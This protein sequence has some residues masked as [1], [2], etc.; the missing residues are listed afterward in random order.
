MIGDYLPCSTVF[1][2]NLCAEY[3]DIA[4]KLRSGGVPLAVLCDCL[5]TLLDCKCC[6]WVVST[7]EVLLPFQIPIRKAS[8]TTKMESVL[9]QHS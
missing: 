8:R 4:S 6:S 9:L 1:A 7:L 2:R 3:F 5:P